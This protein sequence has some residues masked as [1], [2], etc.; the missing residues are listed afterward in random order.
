MWDDC[1]L[2]KRHSGVFSS[3]VPVSVRLSRFTFVHA[4]AP[5]QT[6]VLVNHANINS[7]PTISL[8]GQWI[9]HSLHWHHTPSRIPFSLVYTE[10]AVAVAPAGMLQHSHAPIRCQILGCFQATYI[11]LRGKRASN[12]LKDVFSL[13]EGER[14]SVFLCPREWREGKERE[15]GEAVKAVRASANFKYLAVFDVL[16]RHYERRTSIWPECGCSVPC[17]PPYLNQSAASFLL[18]VKQQSATSA[19]EKWKRCKSCLYATLR[20]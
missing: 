1:M 19:R 8:Q 3:A 9:I 11:R 6:C 4:W 20:A 2:A 7:S 17:Q 13:F 10:F 16:T 12:A 14:S 18:V 5:V 15:R